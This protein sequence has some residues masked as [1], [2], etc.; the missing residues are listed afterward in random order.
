MK[1][2]KALETEI[3]V[4]FYVFKNKNIETIEKPEHK[5]S[6]GFAN[7]ENVLENNNNNKKKQKKKN[8]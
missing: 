7:L 4:S 5:P 3:Y 2:H 1:T 6:K 8:I